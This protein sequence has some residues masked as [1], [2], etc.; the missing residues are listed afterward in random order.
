MLLREQR[1]LDAASA[2]RR[3]LAVEPYAPNAWTALAAA[4]LAAGD[5]AAAR[6]DADEALRLL[7]DDPFALDV[8]AR[9]A[10]QDGD[11]AAA[12]VDRSHLRALA[13]RSEAPDTT[14]AAR[15]LLTPTE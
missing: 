13:T 15:A 5:P 12:E 3:A 4:D 10:A 1:G 14:R 6:R 9:A 11:E 7:A 8:R 2:A